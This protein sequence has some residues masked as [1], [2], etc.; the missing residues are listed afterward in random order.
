[1]PSQL[2]AV[3]A[4]LWRAGY[5]RRMTP[6]APIRTLVAREAYRRELPRRLQVECR[7]RLARG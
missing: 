4:H 2:S 5:Q 7:R 6:V 1:M 3:M